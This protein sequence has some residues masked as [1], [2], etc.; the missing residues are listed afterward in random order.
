MIQ[1]PVF[2]FRGI[3]CYSDILAC[4]RALES[5]LPS[6]APAQSSFAY[7]SV[8]WGFIWRTISFYIDYMAGGPRPGSVWFDAWL[9]TSR[10]EHDAHLSLVRFNDL[11]LNG[12]CSLR[13]L[14]W[15]KVEKWKLGTSGGATC[16]RPSSLVCSL[17]PYSWL[18]Y[19]S[20]VP[21]PTNNSDRYPNCSLRNSA[22]LRLAPLISIDYA[23][24][25]ESRLAHHASMAMRLPWSSTSG[26]SSYVV[27]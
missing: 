24:Q 10:C 8:Q 21:W 11:F 14:M 12:A 22:L 2:P 5:R 13:I 23:Y 15:R 18:L 20:H 4:S 19:T 25:E 9:E 7:L 6:L 3:R 1:I 16:V 27:N 17:R 26:Y